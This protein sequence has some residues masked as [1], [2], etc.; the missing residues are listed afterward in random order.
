MKILNHPNIGKF[1]TVF[2]FKKHSLSLSFYL[3]RC[4]GMWHTKR[5][6][7][8][9]S[10]IP[11][12]E[13]PLLFPE[14]PH[15][16]YSDGQAAPPGSTKALLYAS[17]CSIVKHPSSDGLHMP[18]VSWCH[19]CVAPGPSLTPI[20]YSDLSDPHLPF[21]DMSR[22]LCTRETLVFYYK[23]CISSSGCWLVSA[24]SM[25]L[26]KGFQTFWWQRPLNIMIPLWGTP[27]LKYQGRYMH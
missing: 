14:P 1:S 21:P 25:K 5:T 18:P 11:V 10:L 22:C 27:F 2:C 19:L 15:R 24:D 26:H 17:V 20:F 16:S 12:Q 6:V 7:V 9:A 4:L 23:V 8:E 3:W 13:L